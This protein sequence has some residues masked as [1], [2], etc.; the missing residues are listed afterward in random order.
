MRT[1]SFVV[2][3]LLG[4]SLCFGGESY[5]VKPVRV[6]APMAPGSLLDITARMISQ[7]LSEQ[8]GRSFVVENRAGASGTI[9]NNYVVRSVPDGYTLLWIG[10]GTATVPN[11]HKSIPYDTIKDL[12]PITQIGGAAQVLVV[13]PSLNVTTLKEFI[14]LAQANPGKF[15]YSSAGAGAI[16]HLASE[17]FKIA[18]KVDVSHIPYKGGGEMTSAVLSGQAQMLLTGIPTVI[19]HINSGRVRALAVTTDGKRLPVL[20]DVP[21]M[22]EAGVSGMSVYF[23]FGLGGPAGMPKEVVDKLHAEVV[24]AISLPSVKER[25]L[26]QGAELVGSSPEEFARHIRDELRRWGEVI[27]SAGITLE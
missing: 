12:A 20:P 8:L 23:W 25:F 24:K 6:I 18:A 22:S 14:A 21:S 19:A 5:P 27:K 10:P 7:Q 17:L 1:A 2:M 16:T 4:V 15:N 9:G 3:I 11:L 26:A 13:N